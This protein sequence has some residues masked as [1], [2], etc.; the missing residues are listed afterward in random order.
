MRRTATGRDLAL[1]TTAAL[2]LLVSTSVFTWW[3]ADDASSWD[4]PLYQSF[5]DRMA[6]GD[7]P[8]RDFRVEYPP[9]ALPAFLLPS[10]VAPDGKPVYEP[11][12]NDAARGYARGFATLMTALLAVTV[13]LTALS[14]GALTATVPHAAAALGLVG[15]T[16]LLL[17]EL[18][19]TRFD[20]LPVALSAAGVAALLRGRSRLAALALGLAVAAKL[21]PLLLLPLGAIYVYRRLGRREA[22]VSVA[23]T[24]ATFALVVLPFVALAPGDAWFSIRAQ[25]TRGV[26]VESLPG[27]AVVSLSVA[28]DKLGLGALG[29]GVDE[30]GTGEVR[31]ADVTGALGQAAGT[32]GGLAAIAIVVALWIAAWRRTDASSTRLVRDC[33]A[34]VAAQLAL[35]RVLSPQFVLW[36]VPLVPLVAGRRGRMASTFLAIVLVATHVWFPDLYRD[37]VN[38]RGAAET[39][40]LLARN[41]LLLAV[42][43]ALA[44]P[45]IRPFRS[46]SRPTAAKRMNAGETG[47]A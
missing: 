30:G 9:G 24:A 23:I 39:A 37:Y 25:L 35:G 47:T 22:V 2:A 26:Q 7:V 19:L 28:A 10:L 5:G 6:D 31:S 13:V 33:A 11:E 29:V 8:Y 3:Q 4:V 21:Y 38:E 18:A 32:L 14:L 43:A 45:A 15:A 41:A 34:V 46:P 42:L 20:A 36:L 16:P 44:A 40:Y 12:L 1:L 17:G 27:N